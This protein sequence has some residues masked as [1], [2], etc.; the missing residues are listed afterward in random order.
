MAAPTTE[1]LVGETVWRVDELEEVVDRFQS[2]IN[3]DVDRFR[4]GVKADVGAAAEAMERRMQQLEQRVEASLLARI[5]QLEAV[6]RVQA[7]T[8]QQLQRVALPKQSGLSCTEAR[9]VAGLFKRYVVLGISRRSQNIRI[10]RA[11]HCV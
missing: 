11:V 6:V 4:S 2:R 8:I 7:D 10:L 3:A 9:A 1:M 5:E